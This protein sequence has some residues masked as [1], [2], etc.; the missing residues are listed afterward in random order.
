MT[1]RLAQ[2]VGIEKVATYAERFGV[3]DH[4]PRQLS[5]AL[6][7]GETTLMRL[8]TAYA[9]LVNGGRRIT[10]TLID[11]IQDRQGRTIFRHDDRAC[12]DCRATFWTG[13]AVPAIPDA[14][15][16]VTDPGSAYQMVSM[17]QGVVERGTGR[18]VKTVG[19]PVAG[20]TGTTNDSFDTWFIG[21][22]PDLAVGVFVGFDKP[23]SLGPRETGSSVAAP[24]FRDF[25]ADA[26]AEA[27]SVP[28][29]VPPGIRLVR[30]RAGTG[31][32]ALPGDDDVIL[33]AF[34]P[35]SQPAGPGRVLEGLSADGS[36]AT[37][38][39]GLY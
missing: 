3:V 31:E 34:K 8:S 24:I 2:T 1:V 22:S 39:G 17:L 29:R 27:A 9:M 4:L 10:P 19:R 25:L 30:V 18:R 36:P 21:F 5:M 15:E 26:L 28:F 38:T 13:Q 7:A 12:V 32:L 6:G 16:R 20:K 33:E 35:G 14:R 23:R 11:R 37:G